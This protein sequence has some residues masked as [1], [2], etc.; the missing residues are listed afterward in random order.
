MS[1]HKHVT[2]NDTTLRD[3]EQSPGVAF[4]RDEKVAIALGLES[5]GIKELEIGIPVMGRHEQETIATITESL[6]TAKSMAWCRMH[7]SDIEAAR[8]IGLHWLD[9]S[10]P[11]SGQQITHK[12]SFLSHREYF[13]HVSDQI[14][15]AV[16]YGFNVCLGME[17]ASRADIDLLF[18]LT[19]V[20]QGA[21]AKRMR[22]ADTLGVLDPQTTSLYIEALNRHSDLS[23]E[24]HAHND[25]GLATANTLAAIEAGANSVNTTVVGLGE[26]AG[27]AALEEVAVALSVL[28]KADSGI[29]LHALPTLCELVNQTCGRVTGPQKAIVGGSVFTH[30]SGIHVDG[31]VKDIH[32][33]QGFSPQ[34]VGRQHSV[35]LG[36][37]S[38]NTAIST[39]YKQLGIELSKA[40]CELLRGNLRFWAE[41][42]KSIPT[43]A[44]LYRLAQ[45]S[46]A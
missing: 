17:D 44:D 2:I 30:E 7:R 29:N 38:G 31:L 45:I 35:V 23:I 1:N 8:G 22:F 4:T 13:S 33:Y 15:T 9:L 5:I 40:Q 26:R 27:N 25:L 18:R 14:K 32:N 3:G 36:K 41:S 43:E 34:L 24:M 37:H 28:G 11:A 16:D 6:T 19:D 20:A 39:V 46:L 42:N 21:G 12:L 10:I